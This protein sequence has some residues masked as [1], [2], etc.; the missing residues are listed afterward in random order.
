VVYAIHLSKSVGT[1]ENNSSSK[2]NVT[3]VE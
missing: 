3:E 1:P 2:E